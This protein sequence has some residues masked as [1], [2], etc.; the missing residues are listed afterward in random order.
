MGKLEI[1]SEDPVAE[2]WRLLS[3][4]AYEA[5][6]IRFLESNGE[7]EIHQS[8]VQMIAG[9]IRQAH[10]YF[11]S[12][13]TS[14]MDISPLLLHYGAYSGLIAAYSLITNSVPPIDGH[15]MRL[16]DRRSNRLADAS[17]APGNRRGGALQV[18]SSKLA[19]GS[20]IPNRSPWTLGEIVA[21]IPD[22]RLDCASTYP[23]I[24]THIVPVEIVHT[25]K[26]S[27]DR[28]LRSDLAQWPD[29]SSA[30]ETVQELEHAYLD[31]QH[32]KTYTIL[33]PRQGS[34]EIGTHSISGRKYLEIP[35][36]KAGASTTIPQMFM[37][38]TG[39]FMLGAMSRYWPEVWNPF[40]QADTTGERLVVEKFLAVCLR[41]FPNLLFSRI[42]DTRVQFV[43][44]QEGVLDLTSSM[45]QTEMESMIEDAIRR[46]Q[47]K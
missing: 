20:A 35:H 1:V 44:K 11:K 25:M 30:L 41:Y 24:R 17:L 33:F 28:V 34:S 42:L 7:R 43:T 5:N 21:S 9:S 2:Q 14:P 29:A 18:L 40:V 13:A 3:R 12:A 32:Q 6:I 38:F 27:L 8:V 10:A 16:S 22:L 39:L 15:G 47:I 31:P 23:D 19:P 26:Y 37:H 45:D 36:E 46:R 4:F